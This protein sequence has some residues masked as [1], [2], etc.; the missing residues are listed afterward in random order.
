[1]CM[2]SGPKAPPPPPP[3]PKA[4]PVLDQEAPKLSTFDDGSTELNKRQKGTGKY[5]I[6]QIKKNKGNSGAGLGKS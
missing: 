6:D 3:P 5:K 4:P 1:M 2:S